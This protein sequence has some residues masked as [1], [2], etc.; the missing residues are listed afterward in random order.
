M[1]PLSHLADQ[2]SDERCG[3]HDLEKLEGQVAQRVHP[4]PPQ[5]V[6]VEFRE[7]IQRPFRRPKG[8]RVLWPLPFPVTFVV[9]ETS[10]LVLG[11]AA[12]LLAVTV[13]PAFV[14]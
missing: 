2:K 13:V 12:S 8:F 10:A 6:L 7:R 9:L 14:L 11:T 3:E 5:I 4:P 1:C